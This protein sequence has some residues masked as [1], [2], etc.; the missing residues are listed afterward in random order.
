MHITRRLALSGA[1][2]AVLG[3]TSCGTIS[4]Q[5]ATQLQSLIAGAQSIEASIMSAAP[6]VLALLP[7][8]SAD[9][10]NAT[11]AIG[12]LAAAVNGLAGVSTIAA[13]ATY[14]QA[15]EAALNVIVSAAAS[16]P[17]I[18]APCHEMLVI[19]ALALPPIEALV[20]LAVHE[21]TA[22]A[23]TI[24]ARKVVAP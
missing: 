22:L 3:T 7:I 8:G 16:I 17:V 18:P 23:A 12:A 20:G 13:G 4:Q 11:A 24:A 5:Q 15:I 21:G 2:S 6:Q 9:R 14:V 1:V 19:A 10:V